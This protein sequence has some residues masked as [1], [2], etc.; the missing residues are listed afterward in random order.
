MAS[1]GV[2]VLLMLTCIGLATRAALGADEPAQVGRQIAEARA[3]T[4]NMRYGCSRSTDSARCSKS[5]GA[6]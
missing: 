6:S 2:R 4:P 5:R 1:Y 3:A